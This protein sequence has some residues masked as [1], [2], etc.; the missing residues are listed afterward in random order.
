MATGRRE[1]IRLYRDVMRTLRVFTHPNEQGI[2][3]NV[4]LKDSV[5]KDYDSHKYETNP[6]TL[7][8]LLMV[9]RDCLMK[10]QEG[11]VTGKVSKDPDTPSSSSSNNNPFTKL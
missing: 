10:I 5:R 1:A 9:G 2:P 6:E 4:V 11:V 3:W 8:Q 7:V